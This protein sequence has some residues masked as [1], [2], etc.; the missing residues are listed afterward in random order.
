MNDTTPAATAVQTAETTVAAAAPETSAAPAAE[1]GGQTEQPKT[2]TAQEFDDLFSFNPFKEPGK[3][4]GK[5]ESKPENAP[6]TALPEAAPAE[7]KPSVPPVPSVPA[8]KTDAEQLAELRKELEIQK[9][10]AAA[11]AQQRQA[12][13]AQG[14]VPQQQQDPLEQFRYDF[15]VPDPLVAAMSSEIPEERKYAITSLVNGVAASIHARI[16][17]ET[18]QQLQ[19]GVPQMIAQAEQTRSTAQRVENDFYGTHKDL[20]RPELRPFIQQLAV[21]LMQET[22][23]MEWSPEFRDALAHRARSVFGTQVPAPLPPAPLPQQTA[24]VVQQQ[25]Y[26]AGNGSRPA[27]RSNSM[28]DDI[29]NTLF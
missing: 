1:T 13:Q 9:Q 10:V 25:P 19:H 3:P 2:L 26:M 17:Q 14:Q 23:K 21:A 7:V 27:T 22:G 15:Q 12:P 24:P 8:G 16:A 18:Q 6:A 4:E 5:P 11:L 28:A 20:D 29:F